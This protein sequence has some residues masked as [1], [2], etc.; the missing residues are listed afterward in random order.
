FA[1]GLDLPR[2]DGTIARWNPPSLDSLH[3]ESLATELPAEFLAPASGSDVP[4]A[5]LPDV[6]AIDTAETPAKQEGPSPFEA[7]LQGDTSAK[8]APSAEAPPT[9]ASELVEALARRVAPSATDAPSSG[10]GVDADRLV[11]IIR[12]PAFRRLESHWL[13]LRRLVTQTPDTPELSIH[14]SDVT[15]DELLAGLRAQGSSPDALPSPLLGGDRFSPS[16]IV[17]VEPF[18]NTLEELGLLTAL[19][20]FASLHGAPLIGEATSAFVGRSNWSHWRS[21]GDGEIDPTLQETWD[22]MRSGPVG[23]WIGLAAPRPMARQPYG[24][25]SDPTDDPPIEEVTQPGETDGYPWGSSAIAAAELLAAAFTQQGWN[26][27][28]NDRLDLEDLPNVTFTSDGEI[29]RVPPTEIWLDDRAVTRLES[30]GLMAWMSDRHRNRA[31]LAG[32]HSIA[33]PVTPLA[34]SWERH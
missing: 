15:R 17:V 33:Q 9:S 26:M 3:P 22:A 13:S 2:A 32:F 25:G 18:S 10:S 14:V 5:P 28:S 23:P 1:P 4:P 30:H 21:D 31:R 6:A 16:L 29:E 24:A 19:G 8:R 7:L 27:S 12:S 20:I 11:S 34:G